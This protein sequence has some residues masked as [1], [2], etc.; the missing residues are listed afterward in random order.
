MAFTLTFEVCHEYDAGA[1]GITVPIVLSSG[2]ISRKVEAKF[3][4]GSGYCIFQRGLGEALGFVIESGVPQWIATAT[5]SFLTYGHEATIHVLGFELAGTV[6]FAKDEFF[7]RDVLGRFGWLQKLKVG[8]VDYE[9]K[10]YVG[11]YGEE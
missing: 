5:G 9:G 2:S 8:M 1:P 7:T 3:D 4:S 10:L 6:Y 11:K